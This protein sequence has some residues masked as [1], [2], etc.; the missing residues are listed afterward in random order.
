MTKAK[1]KVVR[2]PGSVRYRAVYESMKFSFTQEQVLRA[3]GFKKAHWHWG[4]ITCDGIN[5][6][7]VQMHKKVWPDDPD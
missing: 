6:V 4:T 7:T 5:Y 2:K 3:L 1:A